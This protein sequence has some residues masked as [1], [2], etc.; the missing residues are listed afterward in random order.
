MLRRIGK[1]EE[2]T[3]FALSK[4]SCDGSH[5]FHGFQNYHSVKKPK[6]TTT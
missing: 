5:G 4:E 6:M 2:V 3:R 1:L